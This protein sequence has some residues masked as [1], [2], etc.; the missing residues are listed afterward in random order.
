MNYKGL[1]FMSSVT[2]W[3]SAYFAAGED[4]LD[5]VAARFRRPGICVKG[6]F[7]LGHEFQLDL[8]PHGIELASG[9]LPIGRD[10]SDSVAEWTNT[11]QA[12]GRDQITFGALYNYTQGQER[13]L[14]PSP[15]YVSPMDRKA[16]RG[17][18]CKSIIGSPTRSI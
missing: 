8:Y 12:T 5:P 13:F 2:E 3:R 18:M 15:E 17:F 4:G 16:G 6:Q 1:S 7:A 10:S 14:A 11:L 9:V